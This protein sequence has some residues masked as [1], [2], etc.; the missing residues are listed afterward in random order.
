MK[1]VRLR[2]QLNSSSEALAIAL[3]HSEVG[4]P[5]AS[6]RVDTPAD[7]KEDADRYDQSNWDGTLVTSPGI[8]CASVSTAGALRLE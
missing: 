4:V 5:V 2:D 8:K 1:L 3:V 7:R 6:R